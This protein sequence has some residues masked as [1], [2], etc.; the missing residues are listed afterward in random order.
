MKETTRSSETPCS[1]LKHKKIVCIPD[2][3]L[4]IRSGFDGYFDLI[5]EPI[6]QGC[7]IDIGYTLG[8]AKSSTVI[9][10]FD[11]NKFRKL[12]G[13]NS[14]EDISKVR[15]TTYYKIPESAV[16]YLFS[17]LPFN[18]LILSFEMPP[19]L[20]HACIANQV[21]YL[22]ARHS[23]LQF[24]RDLYIALDTSQQVLRQR[25]TSQAVGEEELRLEAALLGANIR[26]HRKRLQ[27]NKR[28][29]FDL[30]NAL[31]YIPQSPR[32]D[33]LLT[34][35][36]RF[37]KSE[38]F[39]EQLQELCAHRTLLCMTDY[40][41]ESQA[42]VSEQERAALSSFLGIQVA[43]CPQNAYQILSAEENVALVGISA[44]I[45]QEAPWFDK[46]VYQL[47]KP[48]TP[49]E[50]EESSGFL[51]I[52]FQDI[53]APEFWHQLLTPE[54]A[55]PRLARLPWIDRNH[56]REMLEVWA[57]QE[58]VINWERQQPLRAFERSGGIVLRRRVSSLEKTHV[59]VDRNDASSKVLPTPGMRAR[60]QSLRDSKTGQTAYVLGNGPS[61]QGLNINRLMKQES[62]WCNRSFELE[63]QGFSFRPKY[64]LMRDAINFQAW[65]NKVIAIKSDIKF[66]G[67][68]A[69]SLIERTMPD[70]LAQQN[71][72]A[73]EVSQEPGACMFDNED[74]F[75][76]D[77]SLMIYSGYTVV[78][79]AI[80][81]AFYMGFSRVLVGGVDLDYT[82]P[83]FYG[84]KHSRK[85]VEID[86]ITGYMRKSFPVARKHFEKHGRVLAKITTSPHLPLEYIDTPDMRSI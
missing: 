12:A 58:K 40:L 86:R 70:A 80:Q 7:H 83:Y 60:I 55:P 71:I 17:H 82:K 57:D 73:L 20:K 41:D 35:G 54:S 36:G 25:I 10:D 2:L 15:A 13:C 37:Q 18:S 28:Q 66:L 64:Y 26:A 52:R 29:T 50:N 5:R 74:N 42:Y 61:L 8:G 62:F 23:P 31:V 44:P 76:Y 81:L 56:G 16:N 65:K 53:L 79:D 49:L 1:Q 21:D 84:E 3:L 72:I 48:L 59:A 33:A 75:S 30:E 45:L 46:E 63:S 85:Q 6:R 4:N 68:E 38:D 32:D 78:L 43:P 67:K 27:E 34:E 47:G 22:D 24:G 77:P 69:Y 11:L 9:A 14:P 51:Q 19:W 39:L